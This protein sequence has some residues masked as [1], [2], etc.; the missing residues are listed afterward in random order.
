MIY[1]FLIILFTIVLV[2]LL[3]TYR[4]YDKEFAEKRE[5]FVEYLDERN[6]LET[7]KKIGEINMF[8]QRERVYPRYSQIVD[9]IEKKYQETQDENF[10]NFLNDY[11]YFVKK[12]FLIMPFVMFSIMALL[13]ST[14]EIVKL[15]VS[16]I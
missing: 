7:L 5:K 4:K 11:E 14:I 1:L 6:D 2:L 10:L 8:G 12:F 16:R 9:Y 15:F 13:H 3:K